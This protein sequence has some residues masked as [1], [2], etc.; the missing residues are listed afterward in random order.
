M[1]KQIGSLKMK[2]FGFQSED[3]I[4]RFNSN[5][6]ALNLKEA[7]GTKDPGANENNMR[8]LVMFLF[9]RGKLQR[10][11]DVTRSNKRGK[12]STLFEAAFEK[13]FAESRPQWQ[14]YLRH[15]WQLKNETLRLPITTV[16]P[17]K[18]QYLNFVREHKL[19]MTST[20]EKGASPKANNK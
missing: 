2:R 12:Y 20:V 19:Q 18:N 8:L 15:T 5:S 16:F 10:Y 3:R 4:K 7:V 13:N 9:E 17:N 14:D 1:I 6:L 11:I